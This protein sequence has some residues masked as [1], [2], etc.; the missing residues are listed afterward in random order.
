MRERKE[1][2]A[3]M[4]RYG[5]R[6][7]DALLVE[8]LLD[9]RDLLKPEVVN[10]EVPT[11]QATL[12]APTT[13]DQNKHPVIE[14]EPEGACG[15]ATKSGRPCRRPEGHIGPHKRFYSYKT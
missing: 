4:T 14:E 1:I 11:P 12:N 15:I 6:V 10:V 13:P 3:D 9:I 8:L 2:E 7:N 5:D